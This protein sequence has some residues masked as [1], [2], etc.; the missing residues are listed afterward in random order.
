MNNINRRSLLLAGLGAGTLVACGG[1]SSSPALPSPSGIAVA[2]TEK[3]HRGTGTE[4][5]V[6]LTAAPVT[7]DLGGVKARTW[8]YGGQAPGKEIRISAGDTLVAERSKQLPDKTVTSVHWHGPALRDD[9]DGAP[10]VTQRDV[11]GPGLIRPGPIRHGPSSPVEDRS[12]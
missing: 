10:M 3:K 5:Q 4:R 1:S 8:A 7:L 2:R 6:T 12:R 11:R 9:M